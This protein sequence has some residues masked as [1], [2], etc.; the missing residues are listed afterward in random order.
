MLQRLGIQASGYAVSAFLILVAGHGRSG[1][2]LRAVLLHPSGFASPFGLIVMLVVYLIPP[3]LTSVTVLALPRLLRTL[4]AQGAFQRRFAMPEQRTRPSRRMV[5]RISCFVIATTALGLVVSPPF[6]IRACI[7]L[8][9]AEAVL[10]V[11]VLAFERRQ[12][13]QV[14]VLMAR[15]GLRSRHLLLA[16]NTRGTAWPMEEAMKLANTDWIYSLAT[17]FFYGGRYEDSMELLKARFARVP[18]AHAAFNI[19]CCLTHLRRY[20]EAVAWL[21]KADDLLPLTRQALRDRDLRGLRRAGL[22]DEFSVGA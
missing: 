7:V 20:D 6:A 17:R 21:R 10:V 19:A 3:A 15:N 9:A 8:A 22:L 14:V 4:Q 11:V 16:F 18:Q 12:G 2:P 13:V 1:P 5:I